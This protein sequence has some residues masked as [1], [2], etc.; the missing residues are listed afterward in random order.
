[1]FN[2][3]TKKL[4]TIWSDLPAPP[5][6]G[7]INFMAQDMEF[8]DQL[9]ADGKFEGHTSELNE[10]TRVRLFADQASAEAFA[11]IFAQNVLAAG[12]TDLTYQ[13]VDAFS[14]VE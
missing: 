9:I 10:H 8:V 3:F 7:S 1:M 14:T 11:T 2:V 13:I 4:L 5:L 6:D 12:R